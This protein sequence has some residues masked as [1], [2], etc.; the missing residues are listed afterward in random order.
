MLRPEAL[1]EALFVFVWEELRKATPVGPEHGRDALRHT[2][3][4]SLILRTMTDWLAVASNSPRWLH[5]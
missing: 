4:N 1:P 5:R 2:F 3:G